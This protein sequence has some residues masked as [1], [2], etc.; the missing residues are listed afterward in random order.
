MDITNYDHQ[1]RIILLAGIAAVL[2]LGMYYRIRSQASGEKLDRLQEGLFILIGTRAFG[3]VWW[4]GFLAFLINPENMRWSAVAL[5][6]LLRWLGVGLGVPAA[7]L[8]LLTFHHLG[9]NLTNTVVTRKK[10]TLVTGG[11]YRWVRH[12]FYV[13]AALAFLAFALIT[14]NWFIFIT[15]GGAFLLL[16]VRTDKEEARLIDRFGDDYR[17][18]MQRTGRFIPKLKAGNRDMR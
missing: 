15:G 7:L 2:P 1:F 4:G 17:R 8:L 18:Y 13:A 9:T 3:L 10:H 5:P 14:A 12:P 16:V 11:P 6:L